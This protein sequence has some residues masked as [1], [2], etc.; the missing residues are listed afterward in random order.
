M[1]SRAQQAAPVAYQI[2]SVRLVAGRPTFVMGNGEVW[3]AAETPARNPRTGE[4]VTITRE[5]VG[6]F[7]LRPASGEP[8]RVRAAIAIRSGLIVLTR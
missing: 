8:F 3:A 4:H 7:L 6:Y 5:G 1:M 2:A